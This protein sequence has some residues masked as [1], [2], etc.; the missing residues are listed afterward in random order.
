M[1]ASRRDLISITLSLVVV[2]VYLVL[3]QTSPSEMPDL[4]HW[5]LFVLLLAYTTTYGIPSGVGEVSLV[6]MVSVSAILVMGTIPTAAAILTADLFYGYY[7][8]RWPERANWQQQDEGYSLLATT[9]ANIAMHL[10]STLAAGTFYY[11]SGGQ[12][13]DMSAGT[14]LILAATCLIYILT[15]Y[16][17][18]A[19]FLLLRSRAHVRY[20]LENLR[21]ML[22]YEMIPLVFAPLGASI[23]TRMGLLSFSIFS[24]SLLISSMI[25]KN[26]ARDQHNLKRH[27]Q[28]LGSLQS[29]GE[30]LAANLNEDQIAVAIYREVSKLMPADNFYLALYNPE[31][32]EIDFRVMYEHNRKLPRTIRSFRD[33]LTEYVIRTKKPLLIKKNVRGWVEARGIT[34]YGQE[35]L[36]WMG[37]PLVAASGTLGMIAVQA[38]PLAGALPKPLNELDLQI[39]Q[40]IA[41]QSA[42]A[43]HNARLYAQTDQALTQRVQELN[44]ILNTTAEGI[45][46]L[47]PELE[48]VEVNR[49]LCQMLDTSPAELKGKRTRESDEPRLLQL[50]PGKE[51]IQAIQSGETEIHESEIVLT[52]VRSIPAMRTI[53]PVRDLDGGITGWLLAFRDMTEERQLAEFREDLTRM[54]VH[55]LRSPIVSIQ[56][57]LDMIEFLLE[58]GSKSELLEMLNI[59][60]KGSVQI[61]GMINE[62]LNLNR[63]ETGKMILQPEPLDIPAVFQE[64][65]IYLQPIILQSRISMCEEF[66]RD[67]PIVHAD[68][69]LLKRVIHNLLDNAI[70]FTPDGGSVRVWGMR[71]PIRTGHV[72]VGVEDT[73]PGVP[74]DRL[75]EM[76]AK[77]YSKQEGPSRRKGTGLGLH[78]SKLAIEAHQGEIW[79]ESEIGSGCHLI[80]RLPIQQ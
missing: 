25:L 34:H 48:V 17:M 7:R 69:S 8:W 37:V 54:L 71:D 50:D 56:G 5:A 59:S 12:L 63:L 43:I 70:K 52:G 61:L 68:G 60:R 18:A 29:V 38:Y 72:L 36:S 11:Y 76:F 23:L 28:E 64:E 13:V 53:S 9:T 22:T 49:A 51:A 73:G 30:S 40:M 44:S 19:F 27:I 3:F 67:L 32:E 4:T 41:A 79:A 46:L 35:A 47:T 66:P 15:N 21:T 33:G 55:D 75:E 80:I 26:Q 62:L 42:V 78:F 58:D 74:P 24:L 10:L 20:L 65:L 2:A 31:T 6:P 14:I 39:L 77:Y 16:L 57:G 45:A 1:K